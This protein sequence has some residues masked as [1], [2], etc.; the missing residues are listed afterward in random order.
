MG[1]SRTQTRRDRRCALHPL[2]QWQQ[3]LDE[4]HVFAVRR[5]MTGL[6]PG[7]S[8]HAQGRLV[9][10]AKRVA[11]SHATYSLT[12]ALLAAHTIRRACVRSLDMSTLFFLKW[13]GMCR[14]F[15]Y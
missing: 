10:G 8:S 14:F 12:A 2:P 11:S 4:V 15:R 13:L 1:I 7:A 6:I 3:D 9:H 5:A